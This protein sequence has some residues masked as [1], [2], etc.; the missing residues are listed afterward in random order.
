MRN[1]RLIPPSGGPVR[2]R[3]TLR[4]LRSRCIRP[5][6]RIR[7]PTR[8]QRNPIRKRP[9]AAYTLVV[10]LISG[11]VRRNALVAAVLASSPAC[12]ICA[13][14]SMLQPNDLLV[15]RAEQVRTVLNKGHASVVTTVRLISISKPS[16]GQSGPSKSTVRTFVDGKR[17]P[18]SLPNSGLLALVA[19]RWSVSE[20]TTNGQ[21]ILQF[22]SSSPGSSGLSLSIGSMHPTNACMGTYPGQMVWFE[23]QV[24]NV[25]K[26][27]CEVDRDL[28]D[29]HPRC[30]TALSCINH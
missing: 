13:R 18:S 27:E 1:D 25:S 6:F 7:S 20:L 30:I 15:C 22:R 23:R 28:L 19:D 12:G 16:G 5:M 3:R 9:L 14:A 21:C 2:L 8:E 4:F 10:A 11:F 24:P 29:S 17:Q 26:V